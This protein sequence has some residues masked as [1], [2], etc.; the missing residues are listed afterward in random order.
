MRVVSGYE[1]HYTYNRRNE[2]EFYSSEITH[3]VSTRPPGITQRLHHNDQ[4]LI[5]VR[6]KEHKE[7]INT[8][9]G[10]SVQR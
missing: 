5:A 1:R 9:C 6:C 3:A 8:L 10:H 2:R 4:S 7:L